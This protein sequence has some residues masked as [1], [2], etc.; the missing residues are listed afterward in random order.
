MDAREQIGAWDTAAW[1]LAAVALAFSDRSDE[2]AEAA[3][4]AVRDLGLELPEGATPEQFAA[5]A[6]APLLQA[7]AAVQGGDAW[8]ALPDEALIAQ[9]Q[10]SGQAAWAFSTFLFPE[11]PG[12]VEAL[13]QPGARMLDV[14]T[15]VGALAKGFLDLYPELHV[16]GLDVM[17]RVL[18]LARRA[19]HGPRLELRLQDVADLDE[20]SS[21]DL[22]WVPSMFVPLPTLKEGVRRMV[23]ALKPGGWLVTSF[24]RPPADPTALALFRFRQTAYGG[25]QL[26][27]DGITGL[28]RD[29]G[30]QDVRSL[31]TP[32][33]APGIA[34]GRR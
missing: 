9:G 27:A 15:G 5:T 10:S 32:P 33:G 26:D 30:L 23:D 28:L 12:L 6:A 18:D 1:S 7:A 31:D 13:S 24:A 8:D 19:D 3:R 22:T 16:V 2:L 11:L 4:I 17:P 21:Y 20:P 25:A 14:G 29:A 34:A